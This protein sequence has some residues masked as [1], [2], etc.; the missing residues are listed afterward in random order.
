MA[1]LITLDALNKSLATVKKYVDDAIENI[2]TSGGSNI[3]D[4]TASA[5]T[6]YSSNKIESIKTDIDSQINEIKNNAGNVTDEQVKA[7]VDAYLEQNPIS[8]D[9][10]SITED[11][12]PTNLFDKNNLVKSR[13][14]DSGGTTSGKFSNWIPVKAGRTYGMND[15][16]SKVWYFYNT[17]KTYYG[18]G[19]GN[20]T[21]KP[22]Q[23]GYTLIQ[24]G[25][26]MD[27]N[28]LKVIEGTNPEDA[29]DGYTAIKKSTIPPLSRWSGKK[30]LV[31]GDSI[32]TESN[33]FADKSYASMVATNLGLTVT[34][35]AI[36]G[37]QLLDAINWVE[38]LTT[39]HYDLVTIM[40]GTNDHAYQAHITDITANFETL[41]RKIQARMPNAVVA[42][43]TPI[44]RV[45]FNDAGEE[46]SIG[47]DGYVQNSGTSLAD[48][49][50]AM[51]IKCRELS[52][53]CLDIYDVLD[54]KLEY[55][56]KT[57]FLREDG[58]DGTH[59]N[60]LGHAKFIA[61]RVNAFL[62]S[63]APFYMYINQ[64]T[65]EVPSGPGEPEVT[66]YTITKNLT[67]CT[68]S[69]SASSITQNTSYSATISANS[70]YT[71]GDVTITMG[72]ADIT[73]TAY[74]NGDISISSVTGNIVITANA[75]AIEA[76]SSYTITTQLTHC[77]CSNTATSI[78]PNSSYS[79]KITANSGYTLSSVTVTMGGTDITSS[80]VSGANISISSVTGNIV[81]TANVADY[82]SSTT[83]TVT[84]NLTNCISSNIATTALMGEGYTTTI[85]AKDGYTLGDI[86][87]TLGGEDVSSAVVKEGGTISVGFLRGPLVITAS[88]TA[89]EVEPTTYTVT[90]NL[91]N[92]STNN[93]NASV[94]SGEAY[95]STITANKGY[96]LNSVTVTMG[97]NDITGSVYSDGVITISSVTGNIV[98]TANATQDDSGSTDPVTETLIHSYDIPSSG[99]DLTNHF[100]LTENAEWFNSERNAELKLGRGDSFVLEFDFTRTNAYAATEMVNTGAGAI[101]H[102][103]TSAAPTR[104][105]RIFIGTDFCYSAEGGLFYVKG[106]T[107]EDDTTRIDKLTTTKKI[108]VNEKHNFR[109][110]YDSSTKTSTYYIDGTDIGSIS[111]FEI[112]IDGLNANI[113]HATV[114]NLKLYKV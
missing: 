8:G 74:S 70:G 33:G 78:T 3:D 51:K 61:P 34:N 99:T 14:N 112:I 39:T 2:E 109:M 55:V 49:V 93:S 102:I 108:K 84:L 82:S 69:N 24:I 30:W 23:D 91:T 87:V 22:P 52:I 38:N 95:M 29:H 83:T 63:L 45:Y 60:A 104:L 65:P 75:T 37:R 18:S 80:A 20:K 7:A 36:G 107:S 58:K 19:A 110:T 11:I 44:K 73:S 72:G 71:L 79:A 15:T 31:I 6:T 59:P 27:V 47:P 5:T 62:E 43:I 9:I 90:N 50:D 4:T 56:R 85:V 26:N 94:N 100:D 106:F 76:P 13:P 53:P 105:G 77:K 40:M 68:I 57:Y 89:I 113:E 21:F 12:P 17:D 54:P 88:A 25:D 41:I 16:H 101:P 28:S 111:D 48:L 96:T 64:D 66:T 67:N 114:E 98:I 32:T 97:G 46:T 35:I 92:C 42:Y 10:S 86:K 1:K 81:I 103:Q